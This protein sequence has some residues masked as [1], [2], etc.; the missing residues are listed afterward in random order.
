MPTLFA[1]ATDRHLLTVAYLFQGAAVAVGL[2]ALF[3]F[4]V[5]AWGV[6]QFFLLRVMQGSNAPQPGEDIILLMLRL[7]TGMFRLFGWVSQ[8]ILVVCLVISFILLV[9]AV[10]MLFTGRGLLAEQLWAR[11]VATAM[12]GLPLLVNLIVIVSTRRSPAPF[13]TALAGSYL[14]WAVWRR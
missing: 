5:S 12:V 1:T 9:L 7:L 2:P 8:M 10:L 14:L 6:F 11:I 13:V 3:G 4:L